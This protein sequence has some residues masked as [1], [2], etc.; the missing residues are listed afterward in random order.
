MR[1]AIHRNRHEAVEHPPPKEILA[2]LAK[3]EEE[4]QA[5]MKPLEGML[6]RVFPQAKVLK[7]VEVLNMFRER[8][9][10]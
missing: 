6:R 9:V 8:A 2:K 7:I 5:G 10:A 1:C 3:P 4:I